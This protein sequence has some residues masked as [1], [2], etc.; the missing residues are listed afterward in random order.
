M[1]PGFVTNSSISFLNLYCYSNSPSHPD[2]VTRQGERDWIH[3]SQSK[4]TKITQEWSHRD[5]WTVLIGDGEENTYTML[6]TNFVL[7]WSNTWSTTGTFASSASMSSCSSIIRKLCSSP[8][9][10][11]EPREWQI[12]LWK[13]A[14]YRLPEHESIE[15][16]SWVGAVS[17][18][19]RPYVEP[20]L[21]ISKSRTY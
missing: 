10:G 17:C 5:S 18:A 19:R 7:E 12:R 11:A 14:S 15:R 20:R 4:N 6:L 2:T 16:R 13:I 8:A 1:S 21:L 9:Q 3:S